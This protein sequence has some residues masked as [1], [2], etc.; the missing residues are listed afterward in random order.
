MV[1]ERENFSTPL[2][3]TNKTIKMDTVAM[4]Q[5]DQCSRVRSMS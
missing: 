4:L 3:L 1:E 5:T 2:L